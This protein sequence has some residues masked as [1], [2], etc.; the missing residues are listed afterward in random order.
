MCIPLLPLLFQSTTSFTS[1]KEI[2]DFHLQPPW[3]Y[4]SSS[5]AAI[6]LTI[7]AAAYC[8]LF[9][10]VASAGLGF[11]QFF[12]LNS[13]QSMVIVSFSLF[14]GQCVPQYFNEYL[15]LS[16]H[17]TVTGSS[18]F[19]NIVQVIFSSPATVE[20]MLCKIDK[21]GCLSGKSVDNEVES[22]ESPLADSILNKN[23]EL[24]LFEE[25]LDTNLVGGIYDL[26]SIYSFPGKVRRNNSEGSR[27]QMGSSFTHLPMLQ[28]I[29]YGFVVGRDG[30][31]FVFL[32]LVHKW[33]ARGFC[34]KNGFALIRP[35]D[36]HAA[37]AG[38]ARKVLILD[39][40][41]DFIEVLNWRNSCV[42]NY[43]QQM[44]SKLS[45]PK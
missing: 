37:Q 19:N 10:Y 5:F 6:P 38:A 36:Y 31:S 35:P 24:L 3:P 34:V 12:N 32:S 43:Q 28:L 23:A 27:S 22:L 33:T 30:R 1:W 21:S 4:N 26:Y 42:L 25:H 14:I 18:S 40:F 16:R 11:L 2:I 7:V 13:N 17:G 39:W 20:I 9:S 44:I 29:F 45:K 41:E 15:A 8:I